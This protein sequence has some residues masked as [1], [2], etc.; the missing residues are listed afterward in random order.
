MDLQTDKWHFKSFPAL[1]VARVSHSSVG[2]VDQVYVA[3]GNGADGLLNSV[4][5]LILGAKSW[6][7]IDIPDLAPRTR[8]IFCQIDTNSIVIL[9]GHGVH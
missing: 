9:G 7:L 2:I 4:E 3:C 1:N 5:I 8:P 6:V